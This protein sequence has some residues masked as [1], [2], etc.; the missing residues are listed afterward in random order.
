M[1]KARVNSLL[2]G[3]LINVLIYQFL[4]KDRDFKEYYSITINNI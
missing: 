3:M 1:L 4:E 2:H